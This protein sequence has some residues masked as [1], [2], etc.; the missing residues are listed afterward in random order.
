MDYSEVSKN[1]FF[2]FGEK[3][4]TANSIYPK[5]LLT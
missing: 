4:I 5:T 2:I 3:K 1:Y